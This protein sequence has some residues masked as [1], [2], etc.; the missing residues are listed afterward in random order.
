MMFHADRHDKDYIPAVE[1]LCIWLGVY[2]YTTMYRTAP[3]FDR[4]SSSSTFFSEDGF[5]GYRWQYPC[6]FNTNIEPLKTLL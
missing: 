4:K 2:L 1:S 3:T 5:R 6:I